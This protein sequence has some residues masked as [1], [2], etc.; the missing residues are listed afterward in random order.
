MSRDGSCGGGGQEVQHANRL[1]DRWG[2]CCIAVLIFVLI[3]LLILVI[4]L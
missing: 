2:G 1:P 3:L 4:V